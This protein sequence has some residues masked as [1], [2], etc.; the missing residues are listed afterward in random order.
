M[1]K[2]LKYADLLLCAAIPVTIYLYFLY[3]KTTTI[4]GDDIYLYMKQM[5]TPTIKDAMN[6]DVGFQK[7]RPFHGLAANILYH[8]FDKNTTLYYLF[9]IF[10]QTVNTFLFALILNLFLKSPKLS[11]LVSIVT[12]LSRF[13]LFNINQLFNGGALEGLAMSFTLASLF[14]IFRALVANNQANSKKQ[15]DLLLSILFANL[16]I[17]THERYV[18]ILVFIM[19][20]I[21]LFPT[22]KTVNVKRRIGLSSIALLSIILNVV[23]KKYVYHIPFFVG[24]GGTNISLSFSSVWSFFIDGV[25]A[26]LQVNPGPEY[27]TGIKFGQLS[28]FNKLMVLLSLATLS[29]IAVSYILKIRKE[30][31]AKN[32]LHN[33]HFTLLLFLAALFALLLAPAVV[34][35]RLEQ[36]WLQASLDIFVLMVAIMLSNLSFTKAYFKPA[37][38]ALFIVFYVYTDSI[39]LHKGHHNLYM[40]ASEKNVSEFKEAIDKGIIRPNASKMYI[41]VQQRNEGNEQG[42]IW[43]FGGGDFYYLYQNKSKQIVFVDSVF[44]KTDSG[45][46]SSF[47]NFNK[48]T[49]QIIYRSSHGV[50]DITNEYLTDSLKQFISQKIHKLDNN[51]NLQY[52]QNRLLITPDDAGR[53]ALNGF[54]DKENDIRWTNGRAS[55]GFRGS[56]IAKDSYSIELNTYMPP[57]CASVVPKVSITDDN[58]NDYHSTATGRKGDKFYYKFFFAHSIA[59]LKINLTADTIPVALP[60]TRVLSFPFKSMEIIKL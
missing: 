21:M 17:Y 1:K 57:V 39:Y 50:I 44:T 13:T 49:E 37:L 26:I 8:L 12:G 10:I 54:Y 58:G 23:L 46:V 31:T 29:F 2:N 42:E 41:W 40:A 56:F 20:T 5:A 15:K 22:L 25:R 35:I 30:H 24:T 6:L 32:V 59:V 52:D 28:L 60:D 34:T 18:V 33:T 7:L 9:N 27:L 16:T 55:I 3:F 45:Y 36:R 4:Y 38:F 19:A 48:N 53:F 43:T 47:P 11:L 51:E 14:F